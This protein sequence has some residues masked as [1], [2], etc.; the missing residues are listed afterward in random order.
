MTKAVCGAK[1]KQGPGDCQRP[2]GWGTD[3]PGSGRCKLHGGS[4]PSGKK[5]AK[6]EQA[7][8]AVETYGLPREV[9]PHQALEEELY[10][11]AGHVGWLELEVRRL[12]S[13]SESVGGS[14]GGF[15]SEE[16]VLL[17]RL[18]QAE[19]KHLTDVVKTC[20]QLGL[21]EAQV[22]V[23]KQQGELLA[24]KVQGMLADL[25]KALDFDPHEPEVLSVVR[26]HLTAG[27]A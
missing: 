9:S 11:T 3:H 20:A 22:R 24:Q 1:K 6:R 2:A 8:A 18:Y 17:L 21:A 23:L 16:P 4:S 14:A 27:A 7:E 5:A 19:R 25:G 15:A 13:L 10:R 26:R 12:E